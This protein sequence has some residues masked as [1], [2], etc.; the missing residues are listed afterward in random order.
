MELWYGR[1]M[2]AYANNLEA[3]RNKLHYLE[4]HQ[5]PGPALDFG[6]KCLLDGNWRGRLPFILVDAHLALSQSNQ[7][8]AYLANDDVWKDI[9][10]VYE[11]YLLR[12][13]NSVQDRS[14]YAFLACRAG[15]WD[16]ANRQ[17]DLLGDNAIAGQFGSRADYF[18]WRGKAVA[19]TQP[20]RP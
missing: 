8:Q 7:D 4:H 6:R 12:F 5:G 14:T 10:S 17:F 9:A 15:K 2:D 16:I 1:A 13:P 20:A 11:G 19:A 3:S 18:Y